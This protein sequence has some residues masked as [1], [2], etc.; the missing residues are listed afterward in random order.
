MITIQIDDRVT[1]PHCIKKI[2][3]FLINRDNFLFLSNNGCEIIKWSPADD[4]ITTILLEQ[5]YIL[6][7]YDNLENCYWSISENEP[8]IIQQLDKNFCV[9]GDVQLIDYYPQLPIAI[10]CDECRK[11]N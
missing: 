6:I 11:R 8:Y 3:C 9:N 2:K 5:Q 4:T 7:C 1:L 10:Y